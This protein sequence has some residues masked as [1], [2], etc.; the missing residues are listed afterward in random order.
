MKEAERLAAS[1]LAR[2][3]AEPDA[4]LAEAR[5]ALALTEEFDPTEFVAAGRKG[6]VVEDAFQAARDGYRRHRAHSYEAVGAA[7][8]AQGRTAPARRYLTRAVLLDPLPG[9]V[10]RLA[11]VLVAEG[12]PRLALDLL[13]KHLAGPGYGPEAVALVERAVDAAG[14]PS[15]QAEL[16]A[17]RLRAL[18]AAPAEPRQGAPRLPQ[19]ARLSTGARLRLD[20]AVTV[21]YLAAP[22]CRTCSADI[23]ALRK[24]VAP[25][26]RVVLV[27]ENPDED[28]SLRQVAGLYRIDWPLLLG[29][30]AAQALAVTP[31]SVLVSARGGF[32][33]AAVGPPFG[34]KLPAVLSVFARSDVQETVPRAAFK[35]GREAT[36][37]PAAARPDLPDQLAY[38]ED[39]PPPAAFTAA[40]DA[41]RAGRHL[42]ALR[43]FDSLAEKDDG[44]LL[45]PEARLNRAVCLGA[46]RRTAEARRLLLRIGDARAQDRVD[47]ALESLSPA[48]RESKER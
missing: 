10:Q 29:A 36:P 15:A 37:P 33:G 46:L 8:S 31:G 20:E 16:D 7:L 25:P 18:P 17:A 9:R 23:E 41:Y 4:A 27:P 21:F 35:P 45:P 30:G 2:A 26:A 24:V 13:H 42:E 6:E 48:R 22:G 28:Q 40:L 19:T 39:D 11:A 44:W 34:V 47:R 3:Q 32:V 5:R 1:A 12:Q 38:G 43:F 14:L